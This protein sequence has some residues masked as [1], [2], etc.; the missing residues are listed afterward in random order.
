MDS[1]FI[2]IKTCKKYIK[3]RLVHQMETWPRRL[4]DGFSMVVPYVGNGSGDI[5][6]SGIL[7]LSAE[8]SY[9]GLLSKSKALIEWFLLNRKEEWL[10]TVDDDI[11][12]SP[13]ALQVILTNKEPY[14]GAYIVKEGLF[15]G[16]LLV[17]S[18]DTCL[19]VLSSIDKV[20]QEFDNN[21]HIPDD[22]VI[23]MA[24]YRSGVAKTHLKLPLHVEWLKNDS[25]FNEIPLDTDF[26]FNWDRS[27][28]QEMFEFLETRLRA[29]K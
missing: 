13:H 27:R 9:R 26:V 23:G 20:S 12:L 10:V 19:K 17:L 2:A 11:W 22:L 25:N 28:H 15:S 7:N 16:G 29:C 21:K 14:T 6:P 5:D 1:H 4:P 3:T 24:A 8:D 18:R